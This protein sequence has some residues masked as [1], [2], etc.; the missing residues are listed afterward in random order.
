MQC[1]N[2]KQAQQISDKVII[3]LRDHRLCQNISQYKLAKDLGMS[4]SSISY[5]E[6]LKQRPTLYTVLMIAN[7]L[8]INLF[9]VIKEFEINNS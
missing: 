8:G 9:D 2:K 4:K 5:I 1:M 6:N 7:Y 3:N